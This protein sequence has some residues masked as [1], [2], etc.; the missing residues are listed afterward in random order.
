MKTIGMMLVAIVMLA[1]VLVN[2][3]EAQIVYTQ[4]NASIPVNESYNIDVNGDGVVDFVLRSKL[5]RAWCNAGDEFIWSLTVTPANGNTI[6]TAQTQAGSG[7]ASA[8]QYGTPVNSSQN[9]SS[10]GTT[11]AEMSWGTCGFTTLG[12]W[13]NQPDK[14]LGLQFRSSDGT[15]HYAWAKV[16]TTDYVDSGWLL[17]SSTFLSGFAYETIANEGILA[18]QAQ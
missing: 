7:D 11:M 3:A 15:L 9:F 13:L 8:L 10:N 16:T 4:V 12:Q 5:I 1:S 14:Y 2:P 18:G 6:V 17:H